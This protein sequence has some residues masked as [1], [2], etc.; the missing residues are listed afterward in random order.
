MLQITLLTVGR[1]PAGPLAQLGDD[2]SRRL[3]KFASLELKQVK[4]DD[5]LEAAIP[6]NSL[7][8]VLEVTGK[9]MSSEAFSKKLQTWVDQGQKLTFIIGG[10]HGPSAELKSKADLLLSLSQMTTTHDLA[11]I[12]FLEQLYRAFTITKGMTYHY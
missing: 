5:R 1:L 3:K 10:P 7:L 9:Q 6:K 8:I 12:F 4:S 2:F 11:Q